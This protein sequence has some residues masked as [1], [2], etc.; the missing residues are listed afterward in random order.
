MADPVFLTQKKKKKNLIWFGGVH[1]EAKQSCPAAQ[2]L[3]ST[4]DNNII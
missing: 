1:S 3:Y 2:R 4:T